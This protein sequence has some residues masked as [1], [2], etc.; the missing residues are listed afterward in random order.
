METEDEEI[1][2]TVWTREKNIK[3][4]DLKTRGYEQ[5][6]DIKEE[7]NNKPFLEVVWLQ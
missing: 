5:T 7:G 3:F 4:T 1:P 6:K 2:G